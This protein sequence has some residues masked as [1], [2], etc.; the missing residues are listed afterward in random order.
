MF[1]QLGRS[2]LANPLMRARVLCLLRWAGAAAAGAFVPWLVKHGVDA[3]D[4][5]S[6]GAAI[7]ALI[8]GGGSALYSMIDVI[9]VDQQVKQ[10]AASVATAPAERIAQIAK[11]AQAALT[12]DQGA[13]AQLAAMLARLKAGAE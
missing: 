3:T 11:Q 1:E 13:S 2:L 5:A 9:R 10:T 6:I 8:L 12:G 7:A 4:A